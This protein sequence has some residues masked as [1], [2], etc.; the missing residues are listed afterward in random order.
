MQ[1]DPPDILITN[2]SMLS[3]MLNREVD[4]PIFSKTR[5]WLQGDRQAAFYIVLDE[6]HLQ[7]GAAG[8]E[9]AFLLR[10]LLDRLGLTAPERRH[11]VRVLASSA[12]LP[13]SPEEEAKRSAEFLW[14]MFG[15]F[16]LGGEPRGASEAKDSWARAIVSGRQVSPRYSQESPP[17]KVSYLPFLKLLEAYGSI[18]LEPNG[19]AQLPPAF[20]VAPGPGSK[21]VEAW[22]NVCAEL[23][24]SC[25]NDI[26]DV[27]RGA[28]TEVAERIGWACWEPESSR[29]RAMP[30]SYLCS[31]FFSDVGSLSSEAVLT[32][33]R[34]L[35]FVR[36]AGD[37]LAD[38][39]GG[40]DPSPTSFRLHTF[41]RSIEGLYAPA[42]RNAGV[43]DACFGDRSA[44]VGRLSI[45]REQR[46]ELPAEGGRE[47]RSLRLFELT[48]CEAC[49]DLF[50]SGMKAALGKGTGYVAELLP[51]EPKLDGLPEQAASQRFEDL[52]WEQFGLFWPVDA[53]PVPDKYDAKTCRWIP[54][55]LERA[56]GG[57]RKVGND[58]GAMPL[59]QAKADSRYVVG[60][61]YKREAA[62][63]RHKRMPSAPGTN[64]PYGCP[65]CGTSYARRSR[66]K[67]G[68][69]MRLSP[70]RNFRAGFGKTTQLLAT[71]LFDAQRSANPASDPKLVSF[72]DSRQDAAKGALDIERNHHQDL[73]REL[74]LLALRGAK[75]RGRS[76]SVIEEELK[77]TT[78]EAS[79]TSDRR[80]R[81]A[82]DAKADALESELA[83]ARERAVS[84]GSILEPPDLAHLLKR[85]IVVMP[86]IAALVRKGIHPCDEAGVARIKG[87]EGEEETWFEWVELFDTSVPV[88]W[89]DD[90]PEA[91]PNVSA[92]RA[93][94]RLY[95]VKLVHES[96][97]DVIFS[98]TYF[99]LEESALG[100]VTVLAKDV[101][102]ADANTLNELS[103]LIRVLGDSYRFDPNP[104][105]DEKKDDEAKEW[106]KYSQVNERTRTFADKSWGA[107]APQRLETALKLLS[108]CGHLNGILKI[109]RV[110]VNLVQPTD[111][112]VRC[113]TCGRVHVHPGTGVCTRCYEKL[114][115]TA[116]RSIAEIHDRNFLA[117]RVMRVLEQAGNA[118]EN[119]GA[120]FRLHCEELT[121]QTEDPAARQRD[122]RP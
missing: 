31:R 29:S 86:Y 72:S 120:S 106:K 122:R 24:L 41:F 30:V 96:L 48:Y 4:A 93:N 7:R 46:L 121:G 55:A 57:I 17:T 80:R 8:T 68:P 101:P 19:G 13:D 20:A 58:P 2:V 81:Q 111:T 54:A 74:L 83:E 26:R 64:V 117:R 53:D 78:D 45:E 59:A 3:A 35:L 65:S 91:G 88:R 100:Y 11:Q 50:F 114:D 61:Y 98:R 112:F 6:L 107:E 18:G 110:A 118:F 116:Q 33:A 85:D 44:E 95:L 70:I 99:S 49:G 71:E 52:S 10:M 39:L 66:D 5:E 25:G 108:D 102:G 34:A 63:D 56:T 47:P 12:S 21:Q 92:L 77:Q 36:G 62:Q 87:V 103:A 105:V 38:W 28:V 15:S 1:E 60:R 40:W 32:A 94:A 113:N 9:V 51:H 43:Q 109:A 75:A 14:D 90:P 42:E 104:Y 84:L 79:S 76:A 23:G 22:T 119:T 82:L 89:R 115:W 16:G 73:R 27:V 37:G 69:A 67:G 97:V